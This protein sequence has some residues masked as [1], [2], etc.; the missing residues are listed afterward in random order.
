MEW[1]MAKEHFESLR[2]LRD[3]LVAERRQMVAE[4]FLDPASRQE[5]A[6]EFIALQQFIDTVE[7]AMQHE[8]ALDKGGPKLPPGGR[9]PSGHRR[10]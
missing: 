5:A 7:R 1:M 9:P 3:H 6:G 4:A 2:H 8:A 10:S